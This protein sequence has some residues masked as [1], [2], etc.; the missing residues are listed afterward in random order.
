[1]T[2]EDRV[3][4]LERQNRWH[5]RFG[6]AVVLVAASL[7]LSG[8]AP[9]GIRRIDVN[10]IYLRDAQGRERA[11]LLV[12]KEGSVGIWM[13]DTAGK[14]RS[15][16]SLGGTGSAIIDFRDRNGKVRMAMGIT[17]DDSP[18]INIVD[19]N[20]RLQKTFR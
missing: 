10:E 8:A 1:M 13:R 7:V 18:R 4:Q 3:A 15:V 9:Q 2:L 16:Y 19:V 17:Q 11:A 12:T 6:L 20:G 14:F 5:R